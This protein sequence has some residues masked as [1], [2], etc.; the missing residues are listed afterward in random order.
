MDK[1][2]KKEYIFTFYPKDWQKPVILKTLTEKIM[3]EWI[4]AIKSAI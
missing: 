4:A 2:K 3:R 1:T